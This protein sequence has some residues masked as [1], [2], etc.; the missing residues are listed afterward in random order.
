MTKDT[1][2]VNCGTHVQSHVG[3][4]QRKIFLPLRKSPTSVNGNKDISSEHASHI[5]LQ[6]PSLFVAVMNCACCVWKWKVSEYFLVLYLELVIGMRASVGTYRLISF[7]SFW[8]GWESWC[9]VF[10]WLVY[11]CRAQAGSWA[12]T[13]IFRPKLELE[14]WDRLELKLSSSLYNFLLSQDWEVQSLVLLDPFA[15]LV[16]AGFGSF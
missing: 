3:S 2:L 11:F 5:K 14:L 13:S 16:F 10:I 7:Q 8:K 9:F 12:Q 6:A 1:W 15:P 4:Q